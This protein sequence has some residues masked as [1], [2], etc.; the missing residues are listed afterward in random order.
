MVKG[1]PALIPHSIL[2]FFKDFVYLFSERGGG[3][4]RNIDA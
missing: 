2:F 4:E 3:G 1:K